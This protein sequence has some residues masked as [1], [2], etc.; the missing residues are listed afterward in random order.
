MHFFA[1][2]FTLQNIGS[3]EPRI[4]ELVWVQ[5]QLSFRLNM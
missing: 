1:F 4:L 5:L 2:K 3:G